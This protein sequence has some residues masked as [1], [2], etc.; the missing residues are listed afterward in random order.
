ML[1][2]EGHGTAIGLHVDSARPSELKLVEATLQSV[3]VPRPRGRPRQ[4]PAAL[5]ADKV[6]DSQDLRHSLRR[7]GI[8]PQIPPR[9]RPHRKLPKRGR[10][11]RM[12]SLYLNRWK[13]E[14]TFAWLGSCRRLVVRYERSI[15]RLRAFV[16]LALILISLRLFLK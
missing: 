11:L 10:P 9:A 4:R 7:R 3:R 2:V 15:H 6:F 8:Q 16:L 1:L 14:R 5:A 13:V 12:G